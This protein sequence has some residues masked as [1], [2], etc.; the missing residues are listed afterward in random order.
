MDIGKYIKIINSSDR[1]GEI[2]EENSTYFRMYY[3]SL[4]LYKTHKIATFSVSTIYSF[5]DGEKV[6]KETESH[7]TPEGNK[8]YQKVEYYFN[9]S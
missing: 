7:Y 9:L 8:F 4:G 6:T 2:K 1:K 3:P 5:K